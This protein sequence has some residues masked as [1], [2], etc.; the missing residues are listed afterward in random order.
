MSG[1]TFSAILIDLARPIAG[2]A[3]GVSIEIVGED[4]LPTEST[5]EVRKTLP[6]RYGEVGIE[7][8]LI[9]SME[10]SADRVRGPYCGS[11]PLDLGDL[12]EA[13]GLVASLSGLRS[14]GAVVGDWLCLTDR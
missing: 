2:G 8:L 14:M 11:I 1:H 9:A 3:E 7:A 6:G 13:S 4:S 12:P 10:E 5:L